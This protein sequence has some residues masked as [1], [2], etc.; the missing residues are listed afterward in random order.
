MRR[1]SV[2]GVYSSS[3]S[4]ANSINSEINS[5]DVDDRNA[6]SIAFHFSVSKKRVLGECSKCKK[7]VTAGARQMHMFYHLGKDC[8]IYRFRCKYPNCDVEHYRKD[9]MENHHSKQH[10]KIDPAL[11][12]DRTAELFNSCQELSMQLLG[13]T[14][15]TPGPTAA[16]AQLAY[17]ASLAAQ[18]QNQLRKRKKHIV[19][20]LFHIS[21]KHFLL[22]FANISSR[23]PQ[24]QLRFVAMRLIW[25]VVSEKK[26]HCIRSRYK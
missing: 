6:L 19:S 4:K 8:N 14:G 24:V 23:I 26:I 17:N 21:N 11:M 25:F 9:Q 15:N 12:E 20:S 5:N 16:K 10:G 2:N 13:T 7:P 1:R 18:A 3:R 22:L